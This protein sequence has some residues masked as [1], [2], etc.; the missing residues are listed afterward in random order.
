M[1]TYCMPLRVFLDLR[2]EGAPPANIVALN[3]QFLWFEYKIDTDDNVFV[4]TMTVLHAI[5]CDKND[6]V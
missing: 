6:I 5:D 2:F 3:C 1:H 4:N